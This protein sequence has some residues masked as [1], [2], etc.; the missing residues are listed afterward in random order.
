MKVNLVMLSWIFVFEA[1]NLIC[2]DVD[3]FIKALRAI[4]VY[5]RDVGNP[6]ILLEPAGLFH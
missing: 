1:K 6:T 5:T 3:W 4:S 2:N